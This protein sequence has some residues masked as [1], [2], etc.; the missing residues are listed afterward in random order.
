MKSTTYTI[1]MTPQKNEKYLS[2]EINPLACSP[3]CLLTSCQLRNFL[4]EFTEKCFAIFDQSSCT[5]YLTWYRSLLFLWGF[6][7]IITFMV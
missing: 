7:F 5:I 2:E 4:C 3:A 1:E 6:S